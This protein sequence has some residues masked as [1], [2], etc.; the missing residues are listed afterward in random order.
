MEILEEIKEGIIFFFQGFLVMFGIAF[1]LTL[2]IAAMMIFAM[3]MD[4]NP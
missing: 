4:C 1:F 3:Y 2:P